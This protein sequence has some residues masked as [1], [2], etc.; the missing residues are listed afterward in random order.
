MIC[1][2]GHSTCVDQSAVAAHLKQGDKLGYCDDEDAIDDVVVYPNPVIG[3]HIYVKVP[4]YLENKAIQ[5]TITD[6]TGKVVHQQQVPNNNGI[7]E[8]QLDR[9]IKTGIY[10]L[11]INNTYV[12]KLLVLQ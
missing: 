5:L 1:H 9:K 4:D 10:V 7:I 8:V 6:L 2:N 12:T 11:K 3:G